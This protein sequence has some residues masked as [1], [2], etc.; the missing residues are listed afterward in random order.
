MLGLFILLLFQLAGTALERFAG[1]P[2]PGNVI[3]L[4][5]LLGALSLGWVKVEWIE[6]AASWLLKHMLLFFA[7]IVAGTIVFFPLMAKE[8]AAIAASLLL[9]T[10]LSTVA[11]A[12]T[13]KAWPEA[14]R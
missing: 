10:A 4:V 9:G 13:A 6:A 1:V 7:P 14:R 3:G 12:W 8:W 2:L 5:L 11:A